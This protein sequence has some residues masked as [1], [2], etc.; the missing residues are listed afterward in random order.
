MPPATPPA[1][2]AVGRAPGPVRSSPRSFLEPRDDLPREPVRAHP[3]RGHVVETVPKQL[4]G[5][6]LAPG[7]PLERAVHYLAGPG[8]Q[9]AL[10]PGGELAGRLHP[11]VVPVHRLE[12]CLDTFA[13]G[14]DGEQD[15]RLPARRILGPSVLPSFR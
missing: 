12:Q 9:P 15:G 13:P 2:R 4:L 1:R 11:V 7:P 10:P 14:R 5:A 8:G 6:R 3:S